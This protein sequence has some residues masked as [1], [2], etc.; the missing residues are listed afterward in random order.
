MTIFTGRK[1]KEVNI[2][3]GHINRNKITSS[4]FLFVSVSRFQKLKKV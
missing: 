3:P 2:F 1:R 4:P